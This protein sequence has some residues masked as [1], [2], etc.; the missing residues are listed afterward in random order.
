MN[1][2][3]GVVGVHTAAAIHKFQREFGLNPKDALGSDKL[4]LELWPASASAFGSLGI[5]DGKFKYGRDNWRATEVLASIYIGALRRHV[6]DYYE[7][8]TID[9]KSGLPVLCH[10]LANGGILADATMT[11][12]LVDDRRYPGKN[13][14]RYA[15]FVEELTPHVARI[16]AMHA[17]RNPRHYSIADARPDTTVRVAV[18]V[19]VDDKKRVFLQRRRLD[20][21]NFGGYWECPGGGIERGESAYTALCRELREELGIEVTSGDLLCTIANEGYEGRRFEFEFIFVEEYRGV[22]KPRDG[23]AGHGWYMPHRCKKAL[24]PANLLAWPQITGR[25][26]RA[27]TESKRADRRRRKR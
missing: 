24:T 5:L 11:G 4:P 22:I 25:S 18:G 16:K 2:I 19:L 26:M 3:H 9:P 27:G 13:G 6:D 10:I 20:D 15:A 23:Q 8:V 21:G 1:G 12:T 17:G 7:G 14:Q